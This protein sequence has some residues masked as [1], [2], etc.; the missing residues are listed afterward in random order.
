MEQVSN[1]WA[2]NS[3]AKEGAGPQGQSPDREAPSGAPVSRVPRQAG[4]IL[5]RAV[6]AVTSSRRGWL[7][8]GDLPLGTW[9]PGFGLQVGCAAQPSG[10]QLRSLGGVRGRI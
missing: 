3:I 4:G 9:T 2:I 7:S 1:G 6:P 8:S 5:W 10:R